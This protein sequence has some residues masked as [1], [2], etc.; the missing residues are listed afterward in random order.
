MYQRGYV[1]D[2]Q[3]NFFTEHGGWKS[4]TRLPE[5]NMRRS[6]H[7]Q[8]AASQDADSGVSSLTHGPL[9]KG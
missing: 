4:W 2:M 6:L 1:C 9:F 5:E 3:A 8:K 7:R